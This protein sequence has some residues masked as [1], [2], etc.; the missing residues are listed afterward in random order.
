MNCKDDSRVELSSASGYGAGASFVPPT[1]ARCRLAKVKS[2]G[3]QCPL[4]TT[5][6]KGGC[7]DMSLFA[8]AGFAE[9]RSPFLRGFD[10]LHLAV[11]GAVQNHHFAFGV[12]KNENVAVAEMG[13]LDGF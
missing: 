10:Q 7:P 5:R 9:A 1:S 12:A 13:F 8:S 3:Q 4:H 6:A 11:A 2:S